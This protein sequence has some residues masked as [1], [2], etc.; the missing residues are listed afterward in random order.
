ACLALRAERQAGASRVL[1]GL[2]A[3]GRGIPRPHMRVY[4]AGG[5]LIGEVTS[6]TFSPGRRRGV[7]LALLDAGV[8]DGDNVQVD[9]RGR[10]EPF[11]V[12]K[13]PFVTPSVKE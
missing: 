1:R 8:A 12:T 13:P 11:T 5:D 3:S 9:V 10:R 4:G 2:V 7:A 6:G